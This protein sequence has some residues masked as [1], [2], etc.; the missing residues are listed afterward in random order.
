MVWPMNTSVSMRENE[1]E[2]HTLGL[3][4]IRGALRNLLATDDAAWPAILRVTLGAVMLP[5][6]AQ[7]T[8]GWFHGYGFAATVKWLVAQIHLPVPLA[9]LV[10]LLEAGGALA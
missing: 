7:K 1:D 8:L 4:R 9:V 3:T 2:R 6:G 10:I 5:H